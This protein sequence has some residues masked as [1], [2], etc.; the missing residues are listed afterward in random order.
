MQ[1]E[2]EQKFP[3]NDCSAIEQRVRE[4][5]AELGDPVVQTDQYFAH[6]VRDFAATDEALRIRRVGTD[7][8]VTYKGAKVDS[9]SKTRQ[10]IELPLPAG[11]EGAAQFAAMLCRLGF[12]PVATVTKQRRHAEFPW[13]GRVCELA[14]DSV[15]GLGHFVEIEF[16]ASQA[17]LAQARESMQA[18]GEHLGLTES[19]R[20]SYLELLLELSGQ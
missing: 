4:L 20:R 8:W 1:Y 3:I 10:E 17:D 9:T 6:P 12:Q 7:N 16:S 18:L 5:G 11:P 15:E 14:L 2:V 13:Q 19:E